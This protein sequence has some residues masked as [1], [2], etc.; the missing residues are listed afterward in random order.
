[1]TDSHITQMH[2]RIREMH[3]FPKFCKPEWINYTHSIDEDI[4][5]LVLF[6]HGVLVGEIS[7]RE[8]DDGS[9]TY[10]WHCKT[11]DW[12]QTEDTLEEAKQNL[13]M[14]YVKNWYAYRYGEIGA[15][16]IAGPSLDLRPKTAKSL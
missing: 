8:Y 15:E 7:S 12:R 1:M 2:D 3:S 5:W 9:K 6:N 4:T 10:R 11:S 16:R 14:D 13:F